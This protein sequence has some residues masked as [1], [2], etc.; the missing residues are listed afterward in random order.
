MV[1]V[2]Y[3]GYNDISGETNTAKHQAT[4]VRHKPR[5]H[6]REQ[7]ES[8]DITTSL[9]KNSNNYKASSVLTTPSAVC[10]VA[11]RTSGI[12]SLAPYREWYLATSKESETPSNIGLEWLS[13]STK[14]TIDGCRESGI[15]R[16]RKPAGWCWRRGPRD[17]G[18]GVGGGGEL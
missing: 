17:R 1:L 15:H 18:G 14:D 4:D 6:P 3:P 10:A 13:R 11:L 9:C 7:D 2:W 5:F 8:T 12:L 16:G